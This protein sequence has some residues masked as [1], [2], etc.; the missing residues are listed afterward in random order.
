MS[1]ISCDH[2]DQKKKMVQRS[3]IRKTL[4][5]RDIKSRHNAEEEV[6]LY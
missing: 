3:K 6:Q 4:A 2:L 5:L 1:A